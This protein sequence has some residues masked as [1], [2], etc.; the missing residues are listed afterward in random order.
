VETFGDSELTQS[1]PRVK[2]MPLNSTA[3][4]RLVPRVTTHSSVTNPGRVVETGFI[5]N[6]R[7][8]EFAL[9]FDGFPSWLLAMERS[10][11]SHLH[12]M[13]WSLAASLREHLETTGAAVALVHKAVA[14]LGLGRVSYCGHDAPPEGALILVSGLPAF[15]E[16][17]ALRYAG[18]EVLM[19]ESAHCTT[20]RP[21]PGP[22]WVRLAHRSFGGPTHFVA[23]FGSHGITFVPTGTALRR[24]VGHI[25]EFGV[26]PDPVDESA[27]SLVAGGL[28]IDAILHLTDLAC[29]IIHR[30]S[31]FRSG[32][33]SRVLLA[34][35]R[36]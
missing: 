15:L 33:G 5:P 22:A 27:E 32:W 1:Q 13:G 9:V 20:K 34:D 17:V 4:Q 35:D 28:T 29:P 25:F 2:V 31:F 10:F 12:F 19:I 7:P 6:F 16:A 23:L 21:P 14:H 30:T 11:C 8:R 18:R 36:V 26:Q 3:R 24:T